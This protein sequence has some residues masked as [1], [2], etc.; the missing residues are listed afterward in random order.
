V[1]QGDTASSVI[2]DIAGSPVIDRDLV[3][4]VSQSGTM[5][6]INLAVHRASD[7]ALA[8]A[9]PDGAALEKKVAAQE[10]A[11]AATSK[12]ADRVLPDGKVNVD[13]LRAIDA[14]VTLDAKK[15][16]S[17]EIVALE[18]LRFTVDL[19]DGVLELNPLD[20]GLAG[21]HVIGVITLI[22][23][24]E[25]LTSRATVDLRGIQLNK[26]LPES[27]RAQSAGS[28]GAQVK[29]NGEGTSIAS[30]L[31]NSS[32]S[33]AITMEGGH[34]S[35]LLDAE[36]SLNIGK[37][38]RLILGGDRD[39]AV[40][41]AAVSLDF[42]KGVGESKTV[43]FDTEQTRTE[44]SGTVNLR[45]EKFDFLLHPKAKN[46][47]LSLRAPIRFYGSFK[48]AD[49]SIDKRVV[50]ARVGGAALL[51][52]INPFAA[53]LPLIETGLAED[54]QCA[55]ALGAV[56]AARA[57]QAPAKKAKPEAKAK[58]QKLAR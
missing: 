41:C 54:S 43:L 24:G 17:P 23:Q 18:S 25:P 47:G 16:K 56:P 32:G 9:K 50:A 5:V 14:H 20:F 15:L 28:I 45:D 37:M 57:N 40:R 2:N 7:M 33:L 49:Y 21:G 10:D 31:G 8:V 22:A 19:N 30:I 3:F 51:A 36:S 26:L 38:F 48:H 4:A 12:R 39:I 55:A 44:G 34:I 35:N 29:L 11:L 27:A 13:R 6:A 42:K 58:N 1:V 52:A 53:F 46:P